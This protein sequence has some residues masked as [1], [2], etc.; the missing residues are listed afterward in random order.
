MKGDRVLRPKGLASVATITV[1]A[2]WFRCHGCGDEGEVSPVADRVACA[3]GREFKIP[4][5]ARVP[6]IPAMVTH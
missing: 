3:C 1:E 4:T 2:R 5:S 6:Q